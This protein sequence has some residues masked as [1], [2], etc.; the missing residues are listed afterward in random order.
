MLK[1]INRAGHAPIHDF[2]FNI[3]LLHGFINQTEASITDSITKYEAEGPE[4]F[5][6]E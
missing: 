6:V 5:V 1:F 3:M 2:D 4:T